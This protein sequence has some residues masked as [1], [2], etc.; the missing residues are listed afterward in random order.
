MA[1]IGPPVQGRSSRL[2]ARHFLNQFVEN[3][4]SPDIDRHQVLALAAA[5]LITVPL[6][7]SVFMGVKYLMRPLQAPGWTATTAMGDA[8]TFCAT[9]MIVSAL[10]A[11][12]EWDALSLTPRD[13]FI[14]G[15]L[16][17]P[18]AEVVRAKIAALVAFEAAFVIALNALPTLLHPALMAANLPLSPLMLLPLM[19]AHALSTMMAGALGFTAVVGLREI[20]FL[21]L[22]Q[23]RFQKVGGAAR[24]ALLFTLLVL[25]A[26]VP[27][28]LSDRADWMFGSRSTPALL[29]PVGW[30]AAMHAAIAGRVLDRVPDRD[31]PEWLSEDEMHLKALYRDSLPDLTR[32]AVAGT[33]VLGLMLTMSFALYLWN[34]RRL[35]ILPE[36]QRAPLM[37]SLRAGERLSILLASRPAKRAGLLF[38]ARTVLGSPVHRLYSIASLASGVALLLALAPSVGAAAGR[39]L[40]TGE[41]ALQTLVTALLVAGLR[42]CLR[43][44]ADPQAGWIFTVAEA[45]TL[46]EFRDGVRRGVLIAVGSIVV[47]LL[48]LH[49]A[50][51]GWTIASL[52]AL[53]GAAVGWLL[54]EAACAGVERPLIS[55]IPPS[56]GL[57]TVGV[58]FLGA[59]VLLVFVLGR[60]E[61][62]ALTT[63]VGRIAF[64]ATMLVAAASARYSRRSSM[65]RS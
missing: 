18:R 35:H 54:V 53:N 33:G 58:A 46:R 1:A 57:N 27:V 21:S 36:A 56:D 34:A 49:A 10:V 17:V 11:A 25:L 55:T 60:I 30:F 51:W 8:V 14:L 23:R 28:R 6:F 61:R 50:A 62:V 59:I 13:S 45:G 12:L 2:L 19:A 15:V 48:P 22:G 41:L 16:P 42:A 47:I 37:R 29:Q 32:R 20:L 63:P 31:L 39:F 43:T 3:D 26:M 24:S 4:F 64:P 5:A 7:V 52:H 44:S 65:T 9:S 40:G 38:A